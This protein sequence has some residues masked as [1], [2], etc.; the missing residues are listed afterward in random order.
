MV[1]VAA[2]KLKDGRTVKLGRIQR[3]QKEGV[4]LLR[5]FLR[6][7]KLAVPAEVDYGEKASK[8]IAQALGN[9]DWGDCVIAGKGHSAGIWTANDPDSGGELVSNDDECV[10]QYHQICGRG[11][12]GCVITD[13][14]DW[15][16]DKG[17]TFGGKTSRIVGY[18]GVDPSAAD[19]LKAAIWLFGCITF[20]IDLPGEWASAPEGG[21]WDVTTSRIVGG[22][23]VTGF[24]Y[25]K[26]GVKIATW[27]GVRTI[28]WAALAAKKWVSEC[29]VPLS[30]LWTN[31]DKKSPGLID[32]E[33]LKRYLA[34]LGGGVIPDPAPIPP[35]PPPPPPGP[36]PGPGPMPPTPSPSDIIAIVI[37]ILKILGAAA[38]PWLEWW[39]LGMG[40]PPWLIALVE[41]IIQGMLANGNPKMH[42]YKLPRTLRGPMPRLGWSG[43]SL[44]PPPGQG[45]DQGGAVVWPEI[46]PQ[47]R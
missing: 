6:L 37:S 8:S 18:V 17:M 42:G 5:Q 44:H 11:D 9:F 46:R 7:E 38:L 28:T 10:T 20:G 3:P 39:L 43:V 23:D 33:Q 27:G 24:A 4:P 36:G 26:V 22:H 14:L 31:A 25:N 35:P 12:P 41:S 15:W 32:L 21:L 2:V 1:D 16:R 13:V 45:G 40:L 19:Y 34:Q 47:P 30:E 29:Y